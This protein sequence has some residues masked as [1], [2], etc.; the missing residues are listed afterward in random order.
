M[1]YGYSASTATT[2]NTQRQLT[3]HAIRCIQ[4]VK[5]F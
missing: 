3:Y 4:I 5:Y 1:N 2:I